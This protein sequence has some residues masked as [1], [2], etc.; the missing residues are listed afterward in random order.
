VVAILVRRWLAVAGEVRWWRS[1]R[2]REKVGGEG[3][4]EDGRRWRNERE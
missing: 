2:G 4:D 1:E 3:E